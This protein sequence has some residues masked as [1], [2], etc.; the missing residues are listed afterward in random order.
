M[1]ND[2]RI[3]PNEFCFYKTTWPQISTVAGEAIQKGG[4]QLQATHS[5]PH[6]WFL[7][8]IFSMDSS[9]N[10]FREDV[11]WD[12]KKVKA[13]IFDMAKDFFKMGI[14]SFEETLEF[15][16]EPTDH[17]KNSKTNR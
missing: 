9:R 12:V 16:R 1:R 2:K 15:V 5:I 10:L 7:A 13:V 11:F 4:F 3:W 6:I 8:I 17:L 14:A